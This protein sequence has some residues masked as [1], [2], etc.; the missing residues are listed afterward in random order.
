MYRV[1]QKTHFHKSVGA[2]E[3]ASVK[4][5]KRLARWHLVYQIYLPAI[6]TIVTGMVRTAKIPSK[7]EVAPHAL[8]AK[9]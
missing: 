6:D 8:G 7:L 5:R 1:S 9:C 2:I 3:V 4:N